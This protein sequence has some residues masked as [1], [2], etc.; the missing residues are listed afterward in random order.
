MSTFTRAA[1]AVTRALP[2]LCRGMTQDEIDSDSGSYQTHT[3]K[4]FALASSLQLTYAATE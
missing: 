4:G 2:E 1:Q 3:R